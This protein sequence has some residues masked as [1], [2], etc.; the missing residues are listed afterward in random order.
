MDAKRLLKHLFIPDWFAV[1]AFSAEALK[2]IEQSVGESERRHACELRFVVEGALPL[3]PLWRGQTPRARAQELFS[4]LRVWDTE[5]NSGVLIYIQ[6]VDHRIEIVA[7]RGIAKRVAQEKW[8]AICRTMERA[9]PAGRYRAGS[10]EAI[11]GI[12]ALLQ[13]HFPATRDNPDELPDRPV[14]L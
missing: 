14:V 7:D 10:L 6:M 5:Q 3:G 8:D 12:T 13:E 4:L 9:F 2:A 11:A 1:R